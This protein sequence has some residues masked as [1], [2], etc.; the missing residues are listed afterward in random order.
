VGRSGPGLGLAGARV[1]RG[2]GGARGR[3]RSAWLGQIARHRFSET[4]CNK[5]AL[6]LDQTAA[7]SEVIQAIAAPKRRYRLTIRFGGDG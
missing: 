6:D 5:R 4:W 1:V 2:S 7:I 3:A